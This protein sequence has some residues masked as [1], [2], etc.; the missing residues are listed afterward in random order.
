[1]TTP[2]SF[3]RRIQE[4]TKGLHEMTQNSGFISHLFSGKSSRDEYISYLCG[5]YPIYHYL[6][7]EMRRHASHSMIKPILFSELYRTEAMTH[8]LD[9]LLVEDQ[10]RPEELK[11]TKV[12]VRR[13]EELSQNRP[14]L[15]G[16][17]AY[18]RYLA[19]LSG[20]RFLYKILKDV[21]K[22]DDSALAFQK[23][24]AIEDVQK[25]ID[26]YHDAMESLPLSSEDRAQFIQEIILA[27]FF[28]LNIADELEF[29]FHAA[30][31]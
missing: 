21:C 2:A 19:D 3:V 17:H 9:L 13:I 25:F 28:N 18:T 10:K 20:G 27:Y 11:S 23:F 12:Y 6:E 5:L 1:M 26:R 16:A 29:E 8:D 31:R 14:E 15:L 24:S 22:F 4:E 30:S 7:R